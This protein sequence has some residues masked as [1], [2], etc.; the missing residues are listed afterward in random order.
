MRK[1]VDL[2]SF[3][4]SQLK[5]FEVSHDGQMYRAHVAEDGAVI[6]VQAWF[7]TRWSGF[8]Y[9]IFVAPEVP[10]GPVLTAVIEGAKQAAAAAKAA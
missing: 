3:Q 8:W 1:P 10:V 6:K 7:Q 2:H 5:P 9:D 4:V